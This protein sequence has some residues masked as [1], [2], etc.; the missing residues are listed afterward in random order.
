VLRRAHERGWPGEGREEFSTGGRGTRSKAT[1]RYGS[2]KRATA[3]A[4]GLGRRDE[5]LEEAVVG[6]GPQRWGAL[7]LTGNRSFGGGDGSRRRGR[8]RKA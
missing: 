4:G 6:D 7:S 8:A 1:R 5:D 3:A 2:M